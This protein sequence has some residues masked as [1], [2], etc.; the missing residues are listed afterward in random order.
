MASLLI[1]VLVTL[2]FMRMLLAKDRYSIAVMKAFGYTGGDITV[3]YVARAVF[4]LVVGVILGTLLANTLGESIAGL[5]VSS[6]GASLFR[7]TVNPLTAY[8][9]C[10]LMMAAAVL[11]ATM[12]GTSGIGRV[13]ISEN[14]K[15]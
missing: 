6:V 8:L 13:Q 14:I 4:V 9:L 3:Q 2:L 12:L 10:P 11:V 7:F 1:T 5:A 15:E